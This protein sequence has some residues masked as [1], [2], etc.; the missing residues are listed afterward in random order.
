MLDNN[1]FKAMLVLSNRDL[2]VGLKKRM[3]LPWR[4]WFIWLVD[5]NNFCKSP[6]L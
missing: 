2:I 1:V 5:F 4:L 6:V 3:F